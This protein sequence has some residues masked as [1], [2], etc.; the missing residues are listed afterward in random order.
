VNGR[1][2]VNC[3]QLT[4]NVP[5][6]I[7]AIDAL[8]VVDI[9]FFVRGQF[10]LWIF[11]MFVEYAYSQTVSRFYDNWICARPGS[12]GLANPAPARPCVG[13]WSFAPVLASGQ[14]LRSATM[15]PATN[16]NGIEIIQPKVA[17]SVPDRPTALPWVC[18]PQIYLPGTG[19]I[20]R[21]QRMKPSWGKI[22]LRSPPG[23]AAPRQRRAE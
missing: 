16:P 10:G 15:S 19:C 6:A 22:I 23:V 3:P 8:G 17:R 7:K 9:R 1:L 14:T 2:A 4:E 5:S 18:V 21:R 20:V 11:Q 12:A 13:R